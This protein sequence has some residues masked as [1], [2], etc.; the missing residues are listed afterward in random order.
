M[1]HKRNAFCLVVDLDVAA[2]HFL[3]GAEYGHTRLNE[4]NEKMNEKMRTVNLE[5]DFETDIGGDVVVL[6]EARV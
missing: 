4:F 1:E 3:K 2:L 6:K 5:D